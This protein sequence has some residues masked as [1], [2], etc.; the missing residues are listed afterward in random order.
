[1]ILF[2][3]ITLMCKAFLSK[4][5]IDKSLTMIICIFYHS[6]SLSAPNLNC[7]SVQIL[8]KRLLDVNNLL[9]IY[10]HAYPNRIEYVVS[11]LEFFKLY[12]FII[13][14][15]NRVSVKSTQGT[16]NIKYN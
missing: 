10:S 13:L 5:I 4:L 11:L 8:E 7:N 16:R 1:M 14:T 15:S 2:Q 9:E 12:A 6:S 3:K